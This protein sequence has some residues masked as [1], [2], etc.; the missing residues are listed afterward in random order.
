MAGFDRVRVAQSLPPDLPFS[1][2]P[3]AEPDLETSVQLPPGHMG[4]DVG[5]EGDIYESEIE[6]DIR[7]A[8]NKQK[9]EKQGASVA[10]S[11]H[12]SSGPNAGR[13]RSHQFSSYVPVEV[14]KPRV[15]AVAEVFGLVFSQGV[16]EMQTLANMSSSRDVNRQV[17]VNVA[18]MARMESF[19]QSY[20]SALQYQL[21][22]KTPELLDALVEA[23]SAATAA[24]N[25]A[26]AAP[27]TASTSS[28]SSI[29]G[30]GSLA[31][32]YGDTTSSLNSASV[33]AK[34]GM[35][36][37]KQSLRSGSFI[38]AAVAT[39]LAGVGASN[40]TAAST[41][42]SVTVESLK[43]KV[44]STND[45]LMGQARDAVAL[46][47]HTP[48]EKHMDVLLKTSAMCRLM[49]GT[50]GIL[51]K[52]GKDRT[53]MGVTLENTRALVEDLGVLNGQEM[54]ET[55]RLHGVRRMNVYANTG[56][57]LFAFNQIQR[58]SLPNCYRAPPGSHG[59]NVVS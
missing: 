50:V 36:V 20:Q 14:Y 37:R 22:R 54:C 41:G 4:G 33:S 47:A 52:S 12:N 59:G 44:I 34:R 45:R 2:S 6:R 55:M 38:A 11:Q 35:G 1:F 57:S 28:A 51:C 26:V 9:Q 49:G 17:D 42:L 7:L 18:S 8:L 31:S 40:N 27:S 23:S 25:R 3:S 29:G 16:N 30:G 24:A 15:F 19:Y 53:S 13:R 56:Q 58:L 5:D 10:A 46:N 43:T 21:V 32:P 39:S 48:Y